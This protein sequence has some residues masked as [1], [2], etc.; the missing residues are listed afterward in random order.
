MNSELPLYGTRPATVSDHAIEGARVRCWTYPAAGTPKSTILMVHG[1][2]GDRHGLAR[3]VDA[4]PGHTVVVP[5][6]P[7]FGESDPFPSLPHSTASYGLV[8]GAL[9]RE[10]ALPQDTVLLGHSF[11]SIVASH[12]LAAHPG[13]F[14]RLV[15]VNPISEPALEGPKAV[16]SRIAAG[17]YA[18]ARA[19]P[20]RPGLAVLRSRIVVDTM[21]AVMSKTK[22]PDIRAYVFDQHRRYF[23]GFSNR[24][25]LEEAFNASIGGHVRQVAP[26]IGVPT[27][28]IAGELDE[29]GSVA[30][31]QSLAA[32]F[33]DATLRVIP[34]VGHL[35]HY[36]TPA[37]AAGLIEDFLA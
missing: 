14:A 3:I 31:Q 13:D 8:V 30:S 27:L 37:E 28:L 20:E 16:M 6:L 5:D 24:R 33:P 2:R 12:H 9:R 7:G 34:G 25:M 32:L 36:E 23:G 18:L 15:L 22:D 19:L 11:G 17:Y 26:E 4:L 29:I 21:S 10:L 1:F 35:I